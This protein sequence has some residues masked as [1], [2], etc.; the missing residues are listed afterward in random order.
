MADLFVAVVD[1]VQE[2]GT[3]NLLYGEDEG[4][5]PGFLDAVPYGGWDVAA[6]D[7][8]VVGNLGGAYQALAKCGAPK[9]VAPAPEPTPPPVSKVTRSTSAPPGSAGWFEST[10]FTRPDGQGGVEVWFRK[11]STDPDPPPAAPTKGTVKKS[12]IQTARWRSVGWE[13]GSN[14][15][16]GRWPTSGFGP[17]TGLWFF[18]SNAW[19]GLAGK[20]ITGVTASIGRVSRYHGVPRGVPMHLYTHSYANYDATPDGGPIL[21][22]GPYDAGSLSLGQRKTV[23]LPKTFGEWLR[24][25][26]DAGIACKWDTDY[27]IY[28]PSLTVSVDWSD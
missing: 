15:V 10:V 8:V 20:T 11:I 16:Q 24:D 1:S 19:S 7:K 18:G 3:L 21:R 12:A 17:S 22:V 14:P 23:S 27:L 25:H 26:P 5:D 28:A 6:G 2:D 13:K 9:P 4:G